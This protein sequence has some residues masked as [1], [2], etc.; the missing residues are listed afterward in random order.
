M[1]SVLFSISIHASTDL[2]LNPEPAVFQ[3]FLSSIETQKYY[4]DLISLW[5][6]EEEI[7]ISVQLLQQ[8]LQIS[9]NN[10]FTLNDNFSRYTLFQTNKLIVI[11][12]NPLLFL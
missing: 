10:I 6:D 4:T 9:K 7:F 11:R 5:Y 2:L 3:Y 8:F 1:F 12:Y